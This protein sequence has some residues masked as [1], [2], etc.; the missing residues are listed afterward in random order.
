MTYYI[1]RVQFTS[2]KTVLRIFKAEGKTKE[3]VL[4]LF[5]QP[6]SRANIEKT[7][8]KLEPFTIKEAIALPNAEQRMAALHAF[9]VEEIAKNLKAKVLDRQVIHKKQI[10]WDEN[11][12]PFE[13]EYQDEYIL[14][15]IDA[16]TLGIKYWWRNSMIYF[17]KCNC[18]STDKEYYI[19]VA[20]EAAQNKDAIEAIAWTMRFNGQPLNKQ[21]YLNL[22]YTET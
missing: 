6:K 19:Y 14:Y 11:L 8:D 9:E 3:E 5:S 22:M 13:F 15:T 7:Y 21:Q 4:H 12:K 18:P 17:V 20:E 10:R 16:K 1:N 2:I